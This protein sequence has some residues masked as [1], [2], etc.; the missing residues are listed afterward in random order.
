MMQI[1]IS[2][3][4][5]TNARDVQVQLY[6]G[7]AVVVGILEW[8][9]TSGGRTTVIRRRYRAMYPAGGALGWR[10]VALTIAAALA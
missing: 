1:G 6:D 7:V 8:S 2:T 3:I 9:L 4:R 5:L 10:I